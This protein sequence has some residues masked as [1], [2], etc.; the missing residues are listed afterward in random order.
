[1]S[2]ETAKI[3]KDEIL[4]RLKVLDGVDVSSVTKYEIERILKSVYRVGFA[5][6]QLEYE[7]EIKHKK[8]ESTV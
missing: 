8:A 6:G 3:S 7:K 5:D 2:I 4:M 1:M